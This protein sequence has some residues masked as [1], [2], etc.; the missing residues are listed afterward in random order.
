M[1]LQKSKRGR[2]VWTG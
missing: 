1:K 2:R